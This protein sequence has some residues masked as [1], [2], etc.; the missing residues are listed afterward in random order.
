MRRRLTLS[1]IIGARRDNAPP[2][3]P[4]HAGRASRRARL[5]CHSMPDSTIMSIMRIMKSALW[6]IIQ[7][8]VFHIVLRA[9]FWFTMPSADISFFW[10]CNTPSL[11]ATW[12]WWYFFYNFFLLKVNQELLTLLHRILPTGTCLQGTGKPGR[13]RWPLPSCGPMQ[14]VPIVIAVC[15][16]C[17]IDGSSS[18][19]ISHRNR[20]FCL[21]VIWQLTIQLWKAMF[22]ICSV[23]HST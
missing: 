15:R 22:Q 18:S 3:R 20:L 16:N 5:T 10:I 19:S 11:C 8:F 12:K 1:R 2:S 17:Y 21:S 14:T 9:P 23:Y 6:S 4:G 13:P 7:T